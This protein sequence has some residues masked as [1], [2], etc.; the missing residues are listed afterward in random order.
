MYVELEIAGESM[1]RTEAAH[2]QVRW[3][4]TAGIIECL[5][6]ALGGYQY[7]FELLGADFSV[8]GMISQCGSKLVMNLSKNV[9]LIDTDIERLQL[10]GE[11]RIR[12]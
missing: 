1:R 8:Y 4:E 7:T 11:Y 2:F 10:Q 12:F 5:V 6:C 3:N 9:L